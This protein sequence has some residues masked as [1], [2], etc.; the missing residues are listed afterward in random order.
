MKNGKWIWIGL[1]CAILAAIIWLSPSDNVRETDRSE[2]SVQVI[3]VPTESTESTE[4]TPTEELQETE[5]QAT[6]EP[7]QMQE[8]S[9]TAQPTTAQPTQTASEKESATEPTEETISRVDELIAMVYALKDEYTARLAA[10]EQAGIAEYNSLAEK[11]EE[12]K[13][14]IA[15]RCVEKAYALEKECDGR[16]D[17]ICYELGVL[18]VQENGDMSIIN[19]IRYVYASEK[20]AAKN[21][22]TERYAAILG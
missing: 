6:E 15:M 7:S 22:L 5:L 10:I 21:E 4:Q 12:K 20:T 13:E 11:T 3:T 2:A 17:D 8:E 9:T 18:L 14:E 19:K 16:I 1:A